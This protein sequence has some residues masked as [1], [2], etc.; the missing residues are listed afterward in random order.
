LFMFEIHWQLY[1]PQYPLKKGGNN[2]AEL[3]GCQPDH[4]ELLVFK[5]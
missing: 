1:E 2:T 5:Q 4:R 3:S